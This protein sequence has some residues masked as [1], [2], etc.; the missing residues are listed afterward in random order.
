MG[1][2][3][4]YAGGMKKLP[5]IKCQADMTLDSKEH[6]EIDTIMISTSQKGLEL[7]E[8]SDDT[9]FP[10]IGLWPERKWRPWV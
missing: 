4:C 5:A 2:N 10:Q 1:Y 8:F 3:K 6:F 9:E 7:R